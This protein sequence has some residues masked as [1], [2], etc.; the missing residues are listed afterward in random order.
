MREHLVFCCAEAPKVQS[1]TWS[2]HCEALIGRKC[3]AREFSTCHYSKKLIQFVHF[4]YSL[5]AE[6]IHC[7]HVH[8]SMLQLK[9]IEAACIVEFI[10]CF[11]E[12]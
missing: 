5:L 9:V 8:D 11:Q 4:E 3:V 2:V 7:K 6:G 1:C 12:A 10:S